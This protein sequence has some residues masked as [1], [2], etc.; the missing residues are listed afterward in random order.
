[1]FFW[2]I[3][4]G[5]ISVRLSCFQVWFQNR[6]AKWRRQEKME[7]AR[8]GLHDF[9]LGGLSLGRGPAG[10]PLP[11]G[12]EPWSALSPSPLSTKKLGDNPVVAVASER[13]DVVKETA[14]TT[15]DGNNSTEKPRSLPV[16]VGWTNNS[17]LIQAGY[18]DTR[19]SRSII[20]AAA[21]TVAKCCYTFDH[22]Y[23]S[24]Y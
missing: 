15:L 12:C 16:T 2:I 6:R 5:L 21:Q 3:Y 4:S 8:M 7:A 18:P 10:F 11:P 14:T 9:Q 17:S 19:F 23:I 13:C 20:I 22:A 1:M 24:L